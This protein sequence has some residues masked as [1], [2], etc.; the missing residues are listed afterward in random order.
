MT[1]DIFAVGKVREKH[2]QGIVEEYRKRLSSFCNLSITETK[3]TTAYFDVKNLEEEATDILKKIKTDDFVVTLEIEGHPL[4]S[5]EL[6]KFIDEKRTYGISKMI[7][8]IGG[9]CGLDD[10]V[11]KRS[12]FSLSFGKMTFPHQMMRMILL[13]QIYRSFMIINHRQYHK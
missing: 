3:E 7:F 11:K 1:V 2:F 8:I 10:S 12:D 5:E 6:A 9:S 4:S 13:E